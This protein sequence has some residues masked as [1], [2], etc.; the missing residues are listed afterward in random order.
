MDLPRPPYRVALVGAG[1]VGVAVCALLAERGHE[2]VAVS[3]RSEDSARAAADR[4]GSRVGDPGDADLILVGA[5]EP[6]LAEV[7]AGIS[8]AAPIVHF[9][10]V[11]GVGHLEAP[12]PLLAL[13]PVQACPDIE[14]AIARLP[15]CAWGVTCDPRAR[16][17][18]H[19]FVRELDGLPVDVAEQDRAAWHAAAV[20]TSN[21]IAA[22]LATGE[23]ILESLGIDDP[24]RVLGPIAAA[25]VAN[26]RE[27]GGGAPTLTGPVVRGEV[28]TV[29]R[30]IEALR[31][32]PALL[33][34]YLDI[35]RVIVTSAR[36]SGRIDDDALAR[37]AEVLTR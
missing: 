21:G 4:L 15:G 30:H 35:A 34:S 26:A 5:P 18:A 10:G 3:S 9:A 14:T 22:L 2:V 1:R 16:G 11:V 7:I 36:R 37:L 13:H 31:A 25:T 32:H 8:S 12:G 19:A 17:W 24:E 20:A 33:D 6:S 23:A 29:R 27:G 28:E